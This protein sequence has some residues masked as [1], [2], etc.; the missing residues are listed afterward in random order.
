MAKRFGGWGRRDD[1]GMFMMVMCPPPGCNT[2]KVE[3]AATLLVYCLGNA[4]IEIPSASQI[5]SQRSR[6]RKPCPRLL[7]QAPQCY[8]WPK[9]SVLISN[10]LVRRSNDV[11]RHGT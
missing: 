1:T 2:H 8:N 10:R 4:T 3:N 5:T 6:L 11:A 7:P 9:S